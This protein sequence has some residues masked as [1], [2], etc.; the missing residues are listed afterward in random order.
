[1]FQRP[2]V[3][4]TKSSVEEEKLKPFL[5]VP[6]T[7]ESAF[8]Q[9]WECIPSEHLVD[10]RYPHEKHG[11]TGQIFNN[12]K[13]DIKKDFLDFVDK[14]SQPNWRRLDSRNPTHYF[15]PKFKTISETKGTVSN[16]DEKKLTSLVSEFNRLQADA[17]KGTICSTTAISWLKAE[18]P[19]F[20]LYPHQTDYCDFCVVVKK[21]I[22]GHQQTIN[23]LLQSGNAT[24]EE[25]QRCESM[26]KECETRL[27]EHKDVARSS[28][29]Y[30]RDMTR[31]CAQQWKE[32]TEL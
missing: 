3:Q 8:G 5:V 19:K 18:C 12:A 7:V 25:L 14:N 32:I 17:G 31:K 30:Y 22:Q 1:M 13:S 21:E 6:D 23:R 10:V 4:M 20:A 26:K 16:V 2:V 29:E 24:A 11:L 27:Q 15:F 28:W 9:W